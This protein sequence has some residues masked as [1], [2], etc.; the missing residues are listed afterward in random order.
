MLFDFAEGEG[1]Q[2]DDLGIRLG[3]CYRPQ[4]EIF[5]FMPSSF[6]LKVV[7]NA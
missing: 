5:V 6:H 7:T 1:A 3:E 2:S 4:V